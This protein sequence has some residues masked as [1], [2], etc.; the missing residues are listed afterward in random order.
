MWNNT[1]SARL[2]NYP[3]EKKKAVGIANII[4]EMF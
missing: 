1:T 3:T 4:F 2:E